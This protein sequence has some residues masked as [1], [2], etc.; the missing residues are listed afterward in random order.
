MNRACLVILT[1][2]T[3]CRIESQGSNDQTYFSITNDSLNLDNLVSY[4]REELSKK[5][6]SIS[7][8]HGNS[9]MMFAV[10]GN[11]P[12]TRTFA[13]FNW[14][15][16]QSIKGAKENDL[17]YFLSCAL[18]QKDILIYA[19]QDGTFQNITSGWGKL[20]EVTGENF[21]LKTLAS[22]Y[23]NIGYVQSQFGNHSYAL[24]NLRNS[25]RIEEHLLKSYPKN[26]DPNIYLTL[27]FSPAE[28]D[29]LMENFGL[30][31]SMLEIEEMSFLFN[32]TSRVISDSLQQGK[33]ES[34]IT[35]YKLLK[36]RLLIKDANNSAIPKFLGKDQGM[37]KNYTMILLKRIYG[38]MAETLEKKEEVNSSRYKM[39]AMAPAILEGLEQQQNLVLLYNSIGNI[40]TD[41]QRYTYSLEY[42]LKAWEKLSDVENLNYVYW[43]MPRKQNNQNNHL[44]RL[45]FH[46][47]IISNIAGLY[48]Q[49]KEYDKAEAF[50]DEAEVFLTKIVDQ[51][52]RFY[53][54]KAKKL[55]LESNLFEI[56]ALKSRLYLIQSQPIK[57]RK[58]LADFQEIA[59]KME[60][61]I[62]KASYHLLMGR[63]F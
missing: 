37:G 43:V 56:H 54:A 21:E 41:M 29:S 62:F 28:R 15:V 18:M 51:E 47:A 55:N 1:I 9:N 63:H 34:A 22:I 26:I 40:Y 32:P 44:E 42:Y 5:V 60:E 35:F 50:L 49:R 24:E 33:Y 10:F 59:F 2:W 57:S 3:F 16:H 61:D 12:E 39:Y 25:E 19:Y 52:R 58:E 53:P 8:K 14:L 46:T 11:T 36:D 7:E 17:K 48:I 31:D 4:S 13:I 30:N 23:Q 6:D 45:P 27:E 20:M 38:K